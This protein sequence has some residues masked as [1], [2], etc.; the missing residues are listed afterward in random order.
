MTT[1]RRS[2][3]TTRLL[4]SA[5]LVTVVAGLAIAPAASAARAG[6]PNPARFS[7]TI[8]NPYLPFVPGTT[9]VYRERGED[10]R[11][12]EVV[13]VTH[14]TKTVQGVETVV[15]RDRAYSGGDLVEDTRDWYAQ[16]RQGNVWY[17]GENTKEYE[18]GKVVSTEGSWKAGVDGARAGIVMEANPK[19]GDTYSQE[20]A[21]GV[22][23]DMATVLS[24]DA[25]RTVPYGNFDN[26]LKTRDFSPLEP[27]VVEHKFYA[28]G[29]GSVLEKSV[30]GP[31]ERL[32]LVR[33]V[34]P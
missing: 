19:V 12:R 6:E 9:M 20:D 28:V 13:R 30:K 1:R 16:D 7:T 21:P 14:R 23:E 3:A 24:L 32:A 22:A 33:V 2:S 5:G 8:D 27:S 11:G 34:R 29:I 26:L 10:G 18:D 25:S 4:A 17:F 31:R 15:V